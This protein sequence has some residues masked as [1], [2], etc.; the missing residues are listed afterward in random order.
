MTREEAA[1]ILLSALPYCVDEIKEARDMAIEALKAE[2]VRCGECKWYVK[3]DNEVDA[4]SLC[5]RHADSGYYPYTNEDD[6]CSY[7]ERREP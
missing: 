7:G 1:K 5:K 3:G 4:W 6:F 2:P